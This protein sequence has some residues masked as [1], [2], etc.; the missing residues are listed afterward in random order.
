MSGSSHREQGL[1]SDWEDLGWLPGGGGDRSGPE[2]SL[3]FRSLRHCSQVAFKHSTVLAGPRQVAQ[4]KHIFLC[5]DV[6]LCGLWEKAIEPY[7]KQTLTL[8]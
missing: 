5:E 3:A 8:F 7:A 1:H 6:W 2:E 4:M